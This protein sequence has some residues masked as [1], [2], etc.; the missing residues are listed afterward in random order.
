MLLKFTKQLS[1]EETLPIKKA[2]KD[3]LNFNTAASSEFIIKDM[4]EKEASFP[5]LFSKLK[6][7]SYDLLI[8]PLKTY[9]FPVA[10]INIMPKGELRCRLEKRFRIYPREASLL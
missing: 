8:A 1:F 2:L 5:S 10:Q 9:N 6:T 4:L 7:S 3:I